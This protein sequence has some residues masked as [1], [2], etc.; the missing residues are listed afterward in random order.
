[1]IKD[2]RVLVT[3]SNGF[4]G[5]NLIIRLRELGGYEVMEFAR[6]DSVQNLIE[7]TSKVDIIYH[8]AGVNRS[9]DAGV[10]WDIN[11]GLTKVICDAIR[12]SGRKIPV[13]LASSTQASLENP[14]GKSKLAAEEL[15]RSL[16]ADTG[17]TVHNF[18]LPGV[19]GKWSRPNYNS[20]V[21]T[22]CYNV[23][24]DLPIQINDPN[25][26]VNLAYIDDVVEQFLYVLSS[27]EMGFLDHTVDKIYSVKVGALAKEIHCFKNSRTSLITPRTGIGFIRALY[28]TYLSYIP[29]NQFVYDLSQYQDDRGTFVEMLKTKDSGQLSFFTVFPGVTRGS[30][31]HHTKTEKFLVVKGEVVMR[32]RNIAS[33][34]LWNINASADK[35]QVIDSIPGWVHD[36][37]NVGE[38]QAIIML[39]ANEIF[40]R[41]NPDCIP[42]KV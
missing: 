11:V 4:L 23:S 32:F 29:S 42:C 25:A 31:Y 18:R 12:N 5:K 37:T 22:F 9:D 15:M 39:W 7:M 6:K 8:F 30:H 3:G 14:Y 21:A 35:P 41:Q 27:N 17:G 16:V 36:I 40:D 34:E 24:R 10:F 26:I 33:G 2:C 19:F 1:M 28:S 13:V 20:V 38:E